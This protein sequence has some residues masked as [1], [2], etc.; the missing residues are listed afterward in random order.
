MTFSPS[1]WLPGDHE[2]GETGQKP[3]IG[4]LESFSLREKEFWPER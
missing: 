1:E 2:I 3:K 4:N